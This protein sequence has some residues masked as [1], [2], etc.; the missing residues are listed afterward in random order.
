MALT[1]G[2]FESEFEFK[3]S[4]SG[5][6]GGQNVNKVETKI[7]LNFDVNNTN[8]LN[9]YEKQKIFVKLGNRIDKNGVLKIVSQT[10]RSQ[11]LNKAKAIKKFYELLDKALK[12]EKKRKKVKL[13]K[14]EKEKRLEEKKKVSE[15]KFS[16]KISS[17][18]LE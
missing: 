7:E 3:S 15:K 2:N 14:A 6:K 1:E 18:D 9:E 10:E 11:F 4:R 5:G 12:E 17:K 8:L 13:S 16:R